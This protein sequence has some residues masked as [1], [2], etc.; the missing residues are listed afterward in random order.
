M[1]PV[2]VIEYCHG[3]TGVKMCEGHVACEDRFDLVKFFLIFS[4]QKIAFLLLAIS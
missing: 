3:Q 2:H 4:L 1:E